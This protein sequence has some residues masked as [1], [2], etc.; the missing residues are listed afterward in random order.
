MARPTREGE[1]ERLGGLQGGRGKWEGRTGDVRDE[2]GVEVRFRVRL[3]RLER[4]LG[5]LE[6]LVVVEAERERDE[7]AVS[8]RRGSVQVANGEGEWLCKTHPGSTMSPNPS[9]DMSFGFEKSF[10]ARSLI[11]ASKEVATYEGGGSV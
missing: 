10:G 4:D 2:N 9:N 3:G 5:S 8:T 6:S 1:G 11:G 7:N